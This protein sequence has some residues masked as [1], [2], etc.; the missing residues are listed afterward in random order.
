MDLREQINTMIKKHPRHRLLIFIG[1]FLLIAWVVDGAR[2]PQPN[3]AD[4]SE[5]AP[6]DTYIPSGFV[7]VP[8]QIQNLASLDSI[9]GQF[10]VVD[11]YAE[12]ASMPIGQGIKLIRS[13]RDP[14][15]FAVLVPDNES[16]EIVKQSY[17]PM[18]V[19]VQNPKQTQSY[20]PQKKTNSRITW[21]D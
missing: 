8:I 3:A 6:I 10:A 13:P 4:V 15:Q 2:T 14:S 1:F 5:T 17:K 9:V 12:G 21:E 18:Q 11:L 19:I 20:F 16:R 7:L